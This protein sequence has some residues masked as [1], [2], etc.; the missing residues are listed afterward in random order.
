MGRI[1]DDQTSIFVK[2]ISKQ[3]Y[4]KLRLHFQLLRIKSK[5]SPISWS[6]KFLSHD[7]IIFNEFKITTLLTKTLFKKQLSKF[8]PIQIHKL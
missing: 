8:L 2:I 7:S 3:K 4:H 1:Y 5:N 6:L